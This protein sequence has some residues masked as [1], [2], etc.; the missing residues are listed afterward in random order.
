V[1][2]TD[3]RPGTPSDL[4]ARADPNDRAAR[5]DQLPRDL[6]PLPSVVP[7]DSLLKGTST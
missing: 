4:I 6:R 3:R 2:L 5:V 1:S 7:Y